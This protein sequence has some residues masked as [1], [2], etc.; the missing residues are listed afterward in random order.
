MPNGVNVP[1]TPPRV[2]RGPVSGSQTSPAPPVAA[3]ATSRGIVRKWANLS[4]LPEDGDNLKVLWAGSGQALASNWD[5]GAAFLANKLGPHARPG[6]VIDQA[7]VQGL[8]PC[9]VGTLENM[10]GW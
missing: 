5:A 1:G 10:L 4:G 7:F 9:T 8:N 2:Q 3:P 6:Q